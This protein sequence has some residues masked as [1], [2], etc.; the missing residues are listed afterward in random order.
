MEF[1]TISLER[2]QWVRRDSAGPTDRRKRSQKLSKNV[3]QT[4]NKEAKNSVRK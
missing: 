4:L 3:S 2:L 1:S